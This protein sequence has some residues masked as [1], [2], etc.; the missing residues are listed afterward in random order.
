MHGCNTGPAVISNRYPDQRATL[1][2]LPYPRNLGH[3]GQRFRHLFRFDY[4]LLQF[5]AYSNTSHGSHDELQR[6]G[7]RLRR[8]FQCPILC[9]SG[10]KGLFWPGHTP[11]T[12][13]A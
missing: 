12:L 7:D 5:L 10:Q 8:P 2:S 4:F 1:G 9:H 13:G 6:F 11:M 3:R